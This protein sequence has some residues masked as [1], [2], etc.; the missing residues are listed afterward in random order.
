VPYLRLTADRRG[1]ENTFLMHVPGPGEPARVLYWYRTA[2]GVRIGRAPLDDAAMRWLE[3]QY[4][5]IDFD[6]HDILEEGTVTPVEVESPL[7]PRKRRPRSSESDAGFDA[8]SNEAAPP[9]AD[10]RRGAREAT[11]PSSSAEPVA[12]SR[13]DT[14]PGAGSDLLAEL[15]GRGIAGSLRQRFRAVL[16]A[17]EQAPATEA[18][19]DAWRGVLAPLD[20]DG[21]STP[22]AILAGV[23]AF[24]PGTD[25][26]SRQIEAL[27]PDPPQE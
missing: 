25:A 9:E 4:P 1:Y 18:M 23:A 16:S 14:P 8:S 15:V 20:P 7:P 22:E 13:H 24:E 21:W 2:P 17:V 11:E 12:E 5:A 26:V 19:R 3:E 10:A 27:S 6:W